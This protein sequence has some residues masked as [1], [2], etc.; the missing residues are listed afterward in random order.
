MQQ[1]DCKKEG[2]MKL[3]Y[4]IHETPSGRILLAVLVILVTLCAGPA[5]SA[6]E[7]GTVVIVVPN[8]PSSLDPGNM[9]NQEVSKV[10]R[11]NIAETLT[12]IN[13][14]DSSIT[15]GL[16]TSWKQIDKNTWQFALRKGVKFHDGT[17]FNAAAV[18][19]NIKRLYEAKLDLRTRAMFFSGFKMEGKALDSHTL[20]LK[21]DKYEPLLPTLMG[22][23]AI[24]STNTPLD[25]FARNPIGTGPYKLAKWD[26]GTQIVL[27]RFDNYWGKKPQVK[28]AVF[29]W[30]GE[31]A[32]RASMVLI[33]EADLAPGIA[34][35][36]AKRPDM[37][38]GYSNSDTAYIHINPVAP[39]NDRRVRMA[40]NY[41]VDRNAIRGSILSKDVIP[42][43]QMIV[44]SI[45]GYNPDLKV[46]PY[47]PQ[48]A[49]RLLDEARKDG[50]PVDKE[51]LMTARISQYP[52]SDE[53][54][55][56]LM[57]MYR[58][59]GL[60]IKL[61]LV[62]T[63]VIMKNYQAKPYPAE[64]YLLVKTHDNNKGD[65]GFT[66]FFK[67][68]CN[69]NQSTTCD[70]E[71]DAL[72][73]KA[74]VATGEERRKLWQAAFKRIHEEIVPDVMLYHLVEYTRVGNRINFK[75]SIETNS[76]IPLAKITFK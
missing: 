44:P 39:F 64:P 5:Y 11:R 28:K 33:G 63:A 60:N 54:A 34:A 30:R 41:A 3:G 8:E 15:P 49:K 70:K 18:I 66:V 23:L 51:I 56:T 52:G 72:I 46:W 16:A 6:S 53:L 42:A 17:D 68:H 31:S 37:D 20:E 43:T 21:T 35:Q 13:S 9:N 57:S 22:I 76:Q 62:E 47:D 4:V 50:V 36:D 32:V 58:A 75:P 71:V 38:Y 2:I 29:I 67:Y 69:G 19:F 27:E 48:R 14:E 40:L 7:P 61:K 1:I 74:Q 24:C 55:E 45:A 10:L 26:T 59:V 25:K 73:E 65:A 12:E